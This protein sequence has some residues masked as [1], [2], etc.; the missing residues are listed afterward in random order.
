[1][2]RP[3]MLGTGTRVALFAAVVAAAAVD[4]AP[5]VAA[6]PAGPGPAVSF[7]SSSFQMSAVA[8]ANADNVWA[9]GDSSSAGFIA[10]WNGHTWT[11]QPSWNPSTPHF[12]L[13]QG[14][15]ADRPD[16][17]WAVGSTNGA[18]D[19]GYETTVVEHWNGQAWVHVPSPDP[20]PAGTDN[21]NDLTSVVASSPTNVWVSG[22][23]RDQTTGKSGMLLLHWDG[24]SWK[25]V[26][27]PPE[28]PSGGLDL[29][30]T[31]T[32]GSSSVWLAGSQFPSSGQTRTAVF[33]W[34]G[35]G[36]TRRASANLGTFDSL[37]AAT[38]DGW[39]VGYYWNAA[40]VYQ[41]LILRWNGRSYVPAS[42]PQIGGATEENLL[43]DVVST[44]PSNA[45]AVGWNHVGPTTAASE[46]TLILHWNGKT[47]S[48]VA[49]PDPFTA[50][51]PAENLAGVA[52]V[53]TKAAWATGFATGCGLD[54]GHGYVLQWNGRSWQQS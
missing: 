1:M 18:H 26:T 54:C 9:V 29:Q 42:H 48:H 8:A 24:A 27:P 35:K 32:T 52:A 19:T 44:G 40:G 36:W 46:D 22:G 47:W 21:I 39:A 41:S 34:N 16:D 14:V 12:T 11:E 5:T 53:G 45:W 13:L 17:A 2:L 3:A 25:S 28:P 15:A 30:V 43:R 49:S 51:A 6:T 4:P 38:A 31:A 37:S 33:Y 23:W 7:P 50:A 20:A 10:Y